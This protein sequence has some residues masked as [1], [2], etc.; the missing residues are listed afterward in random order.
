MYIKSKEISENYK[1]CYYSIF[2]F[3]TEKNLSIIDGKLYKFQK[4]FYNLSE[5]I[6]YFCRESIISRRF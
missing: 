6:P 1:N 2:I 3:V 4:F 5:V